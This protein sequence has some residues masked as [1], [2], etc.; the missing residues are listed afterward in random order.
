MTDKDLKGNVQGALEWEPSINAADI[1]V[2]VDHGVVTLH[3]TVN[4]YAHK[5]T[6]ERVTSACGE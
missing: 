4:S 1:G 2:T 3:A 6:A 5:M